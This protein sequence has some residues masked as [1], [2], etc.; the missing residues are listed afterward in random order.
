MR[1]RAL[2][3]LIVPVCLILAPTAATAKKLQPA[4]DHAA[5]G[6]PI[7][8]IT[9]VIAEVKRELA[10]AQSKPGTGVGLKLDSVELS[11]ALTKTTDTNGKISV[12]VPILGG[13]DLGGSGTK[14]VEE[15]SSLVITLTPPTPTPA[16]AGEDVKDLGLTQA[17]LDVRDQL[18]KGMAGE[19]RLDPSKVVL[20]LKFV[21]TKA[22]GGTGQIKFLVFTIGGGTTLTAANSNSIALNFSKGKT[23]Q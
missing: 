7:F 17:I 21:V 10:A 22:V 15:T 13:V 14:K 23:L 18:S 11:F 2:T 1:K 6:A 9:D 20:T 19:P 4:P 3:S 5:A 12:G 16:M 8:P